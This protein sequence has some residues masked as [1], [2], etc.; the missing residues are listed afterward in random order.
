[1]TTSQLRLNP[2]RAIPVAFALIFNVVFG[3]MAPF[4]QS[5]LTGPTSAL[6]YVGD[7]GT[8]E[9]DG[10]AYHAD[11]SHDW[12][13]V[14]TDRN[15]PPFPAS[16][17]NNVVFATD[18]TGAGD[19]ILTGGSTK[20][21]YDL[22]SWL[23]KQSAS[24]SVQDKDDIENAFA[25]AYTA[26]NGHT[27]GYFGLDRYSIDGDATAGFW[28]F[29]DSVAKTG[30]GTGSGTGFTGKHSEGDI[31]V[32]IDFVNGGSQGEAT[33]YYWHNN[34]LTLKT[35]GG[36]CDGSSQDACAI[37]NIVDANSPWSYTPK[38]GTADVF[39]A[40]D[41]KKNGS[42]GAG[43]LYE[44]GIDLTALGL[45]TG[46]FSSF[47]AETRSS[48][49]TTSTLSDFVLGNFSFCAP[50]TIETQVSDSSVSVGDS[51]TDTATLSGD[52]GDVEGTVDFFLCGP[53][54][55]APDCS[56]GGAK[57]GATKTISNGDGDL[58]FLRGRYRRARTASARSTRPRKAPST[59]LRHTP[60]RQP[61]A[62]R[63]S[64]RRST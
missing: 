29:K 53:G 33:V 11:T 34:A 16:A 47:M 60:T 15:G 51:V 17:A 41:V 43:A 18:I 49:E 55:S 30:S 35:T 1:M 57:V 58:G 20:D 3:P 63:S 36:E 27:V 61:N 12:D 2:F 48:Q 8:F 32:V 21:I 26:S 62:L 42:Q 46:C 10:N 64:P 37:T 13:Q 9:L 59:W 54:N 39:P 38:S 23:W 24:T 7:S 40:A 50:P 44:G 25:A 45:D 14:Y 19:D 22:P 52:K 56:T 28:F 5:Q 6:A 31:L 4:L